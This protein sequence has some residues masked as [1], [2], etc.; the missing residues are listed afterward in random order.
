MRSQGQRA[1]FADE[2]VE[3]NGAIGGTYAHRLMT[4]L[5]GFEGLLQQWAKTVEQPLHQALAD[6]RNDRKRATRAKLMGQIRL[7]RNIRVQA[8]HKLELAK[9]GAVARAEPIIAKLQATQATVP[10][11]VHVLSHLPQGADGARRD[12]LNHRAPQP[13]HDP[14]WGW[15]E[16]QVANNEATVRDMEQ[17]VARLKSPRKEWQT[18]LRKRPL[19]EVSEYYRQ[20]GQEWK[21]SS[22]QPGYAAY[23]PKWQGLKAD[24]KTGY[25]PWDGK[26]RDG[27]RGDG[28]GFHEFSFADP[29]RKA[30][31][32]GLYQEHEE[33][34][35]VQNLRH[36][37]PGHP[38]PLE[39]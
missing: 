34:M 5:R 6:D 32:H 25:K 17:Q 23:K 18:A 28:E 12:L 2:A 33:R 35:K 1:H 11:D 30:D 39:D 19:R 3:R 38:D 14:H 27:R 10:K 4:S 20:A 22:A 21:W 36:W 7:A 26:Y 9:Q 29:E 15:V 8:D 13:E 31:R 24:K 37:R 16:R